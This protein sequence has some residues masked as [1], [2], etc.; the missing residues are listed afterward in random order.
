M[1]VELNY[2]LLQ[3]SWKHFRAIHSKYPTR[4]LFSDEDLL[5]HACNLKEGQTSNRLITS[6]DMPPLS[7][8]ELFILDE[9]IRAGHGWS[10]VMAS[11]AYPRF[12]RYSTDTHGAYYCA[13]NIETALK[14]WS[15]HTAKYW[16]DEMG[17]TN[18]V[19]AI[20]RAYT[21]HFDK[22]LVDVRGNALLHTN[23]YSAPQVL[24]ANALSNQQHGILYNS[25]RNEGTGICAALLRPSAT[26]AVKQYAHFA[27]IYDGGSFTS[28]SKLGPI[29]PLT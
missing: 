14:E 16:R 18:E 21:G 27:L 28:Y 10:T 2:P 24:L 17:F 26:T 13:N 9:D 12:G 22:P 5:N 6:G 4:N 1:H 11:F 15:Y 25:V 3:P 19:S 20:T 8:R 29:K 7:P 23:D